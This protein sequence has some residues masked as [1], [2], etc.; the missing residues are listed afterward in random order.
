MPKPNMSSHRETLLVIVVDFTSIPETYVFVGTLTRMAKES[1]HLRSPPLAGGSAGG[2]LIR[3]RRRPFAGG[4]KVRS[5]SASRFF[6]RRI[7]PPLPL[8]SARLRSRRFTHARLYSD[9]GEV[10]ICG[11]LIFVILASR[12]VLKQS[13]CR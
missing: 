13:T 10:V 11:T 3:L 1:V 5:V 9:A 7:S 4:R 8:A 6:R 12:R 2:A